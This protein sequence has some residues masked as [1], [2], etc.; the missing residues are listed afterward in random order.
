[1]VVGFGVVGLAVVVHLASLAVA[2][3]HENLVVSTTG[4]KYV[5]FGVGA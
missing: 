3:E 2:A 1:L 4:G 5:G